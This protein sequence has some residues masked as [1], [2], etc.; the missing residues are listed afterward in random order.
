MIRAALKSFPTCRVFQPGAF[1]LLLF[2]AGCGS[3]FA[4]PQSSQNSYEKVPGTNFPTVMHIC[5]GGC[6]RGNGVMFVWQNGHYVNAADPGDKAALTIEKLT[7]DSVVIQ[8]VD[9]GRYSGRAT[10]TG[11]LS[12]D[13]ESIINGKI[14]WTYHPCCGLSSGPFRAAWGAA[15]NTVPGRKG[16]RPAAP[17]ASQE[18][19][20][21][22]P[23]PK[24]SPPQNSVS[25]NPAIQ[26]AASSNPSQSSSVR[27]PSP[28][29]S[30]SRE[31]TPAAPTVAPSTSASVSAAASAQP[32]NVVA[33]PTGRKL[34]HN[35]NGIWEADFGTP[36][37]ANFHHEKILVYQLRN[38]IQFLN[39]EGRRFVRPGV[40]FLIASDLLDNIPATIKAAVLAP[41][42]KGM[43]QLYST[44]LII[45]DAEHLH[46]ANEPTFHRTSS[47]EVADVECQPGNLNHIDAQDAF[48]R[49][50]AFFV[51][52]EVAVG[53]CWYRVAA[54]QGHPRAQSSYAYALRMGQI[55]GKPNI[56]EAYKWA[57][58]SAEQRDPYGENELGVDLGIIA[59]LEA[60]KQG[61]EIADRAFLH[62]PDRIYLG[63]Q[64]SVAAPSMP[65]FIADKSVSINH[66]CDPVKDRS[67]ALG[68]AYGFAKANYAGKNYGTAACWLY[69]SAMQG[70]PDAALALGLFSHL[71]LSVSKDDTQAFLW[72]RRSAGA[73]DLEA[74]Q[75]VAHCLK[76]GVGVSAD[77]E[78]AQLWTNQANEQIQLAKALLAQRRKEAAQNAADRASVLF[79]INML[80]MGPQSHGDRVEGYM[81][82]GKSYS[83]AES[84]ANDDEDS[85][86]F[87][88]WMFSRQGL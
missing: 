70:N 9:G 43:V 25:Q 69:V 37:T 3:L 47:R 72:F 10:I 6:D 1:F 30:A 51:V 44:S 38:S 52:K 63:D 53:D 21:T 75:L 33:F 77:P 86:G 65:A 57:Q 22:S 19:V 84:L 14:K 34:A 56:P 17:L 2:I 8:R 28:A 85:E 41:N 82:G 7:K 35:I 11:Q 16:D 42:G 78:R 27:P 74:E 68:A 40:Q 13:S 73:E 15:I 49:A 88:S 60:A 39:I 80:G 76:F 20:R 87:W 61:Q 67:V 4:S 26:S 29:I 23:P 64:K 55:G 31:P 24:S 48:Y 83:D 5:I 32:S 71:G 46:I 54:E 79:L 45:D 18:A 58:K 12:E 66:P 81:A 36:G 50:Q 62:D 59:P